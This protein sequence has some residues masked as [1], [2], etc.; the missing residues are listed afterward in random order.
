VTDDQ[1]L[2]T[3]APEAPVAE[4][5]GAGQTGEEPAPQ[6]RLPT[7]FGQ[8]IA[9]KGGLPSDLERRIREIEDRD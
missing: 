5:P 7:D 8:Q 1:A 6:V 4:S 9:A 2:P 3:S